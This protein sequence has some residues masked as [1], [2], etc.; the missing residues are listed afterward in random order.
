MTIVSLKSFKFMPV[1][2]KWDT[3]II[4]DID[5]QDAYNV[6]YDIRKIRDAMINPTPENC[7]WGFW[8]ESTG[9][10]HTYMTAAMLVGK[11]FTVRCSKKSIA[12]KVEKLIK[13][14][15]SNINISGESIF[16]Y[17]RDEWFDN[18]VHGRSVWR[19]DRT[20]E[21]PYGVVIDRV[22]P[23]TLQMIQHPEKGYKM[24][25]QRAM[26]Y[27]EPYTSAEDFY[28]NYNPLHPPILEPV[29]VKIP[30]DSDVILHSRHFHQAPIKA[31]L[32]YIIYKL[33]ILKF[34]RKYA[35][36]H[37]APLL[38]GG[39]GEPGKFIPRKKDMKLISDKLKLIFE[40]IHNFSALTLPGY[41]KVQSFEPSGGGRAAEIYVEYIDM[42]DRQIMFT[43]FGSM[44][45]RDAS[46]RTHATQRGIREDQFMFLTGVQT[47]RA[48]YLSNFYANVLCKE[49]GIDNCS[50]DDLHFEWSPLTFTPWDVLTQGIMNMVDV[51]VMD[52]KTEARDLLRTLFPNLPEAND[53]GKLINPIA[54]EKTKPKPNTG[55]APAG[56]ANT[57]ASNP[58]ASKS[59]PRV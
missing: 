29:W 50:P 19:I 49:N 43:L 38:I 35:E 12:D 59:T 1:G 36:K 23:V 26:T 52:D 17:L 27:R 2:T 46:G 9:Q 33:W 47:R 34:M 11:G 3:P 58:R 53:S 45:T 41:I 40:N 57:R 51:G 31:A 25:I 44:A 28:M 8:N 18:I 14:F 48:E 15:N 37:W 39:I 5:I 56:S 54:I 7:D 32:K 30:V 16:D 22:D 4:T 55:G 24:F 13:G 10:S 20:R 6:D 21:S 42:L